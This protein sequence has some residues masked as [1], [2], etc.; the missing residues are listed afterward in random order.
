MIEKLEFYHGAALVRLIEDPRCETIGKHAC[1]YRVNQ[2]RLVA[3]KYSTKAHSP[4]GFTF[5]QDDID[6]LQAAGQEF[7]GCLIAFVCGGDGV[8][9]LSWTTVADL[10]GNAPGGISA[11]RSFAGCYAVSGPA[12][13]LKGK[14]AM[15]RWPAIVFDGEESN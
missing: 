7:G 3:I 2:Q 5:S 14:I 9:A 15:N 12:G 1:G 11:K 8:C 4:W 10:L 6:R 13:T